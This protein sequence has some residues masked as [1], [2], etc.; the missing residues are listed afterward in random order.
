MAQPCSGS[1]EQVRYIEQN[2]PEAKLEQASR[3]PY[4]GRDQGS[5]VMRKNRLK[6]VEWP[7]THDQHP[8][9]AVETLLKSG[10]HHPLSGRA[11]DLDEHFK[12]K[13]STLISVCTVRDFNA[14]T[15]VEI[16]RIN[17]QI[18]CMEL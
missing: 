10:R 13:S 5:P 2:I 4:I 18:K 3:S 7:E 6:V 11:V 9:Y 12:I 8:V 17:L 16:E 15:E 1:P 14:K